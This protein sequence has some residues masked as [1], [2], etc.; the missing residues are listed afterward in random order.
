MPKLQTI[1]NLEPNLTYPN[2]TPNLTPQK[3]SRSPTVNEICVDGNREEKLMMTKVF[4]SNGEPLKFDRTSSR[5]K[6]DGCRRARGADAAAAGRLRRCR[7]RRRSRRTARRAP[8]AAIRI[9]WPGT[10]DEKQINQRM[11][12]SAEARTYWERMI[13]A[14]LGKTQ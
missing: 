4:Y 8:P 9:P 13:S 2:P 11:T 6:A 3:M 12:S 10:T 14:T 5:T 1:S 7:R